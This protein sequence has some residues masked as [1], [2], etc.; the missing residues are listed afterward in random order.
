MKLYIVY[1]SSE[2]PG[3]NRPPYFTKRRALLSL[4]RAAAELDS[5]VVDITFLNDGEIGPDRLQLMERAGT[6]N[7]LPGLGNSRSYRQAIGLVDRLGANDVDIAYLAEDDYLYVPSALKELVAAARSIPEATYFTL[8]DHPDRYSRDTDSSNGSRIWVAG[9]RHW[10][11]TDSTCM[12]FAARVHS[13]RSDSWMHWLGTRKDY[14]DDSNMWRAL[15]GA[16]A[17]RAT[18]SMAEIPVIPPDRLVWRHVVKRVLRLSRGGPALLVSPMPSL[19]THAED[20]LTAP[21]VDWEQVAEE[22]ESWA[23]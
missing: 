17:Y 23:R 19:A 1:R 8:Y 3:K 14:P 11:T 22:A 15:Q 13:L 4:L 21:F 2:S 5:D 18:S 6:V 12:T 16:D 10:R 20:G 7:S 9:D